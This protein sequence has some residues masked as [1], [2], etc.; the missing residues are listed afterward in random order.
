MLEKLFRAGTNR[1]VEK[2]T[3]VTSPTGE[4]V[5]TE[6]NGWDMLIDL[7]NLED[8]TVTPNSA[9][10]FNTVYAC[11]N[12]LSDDLAKLPWKAYKKTN[13]AITRGNSHPVDYLLNKRP[14]PHMNP[15]T[16]K[17]TLMVDVLTQ[18][19][20]YALIEYDEQGKPRVM[21][22]LTSHMTSYIVDEKTG[23]SGYRTKWRNNDILLQDYEVFHI[24]ALGN[25][26]EGVSP[27]ESVKLQ[28]E[29]SYLSDQFNNGMIRSG[30]VPK[31]IL[32]VQGAIGKEAK[33]NVRREWKRSNS[34][35]AIAIIDN[36]L[37]Y[38]SMGISQQD[39]QFV[40]AKRYNAQE[41]ASIFKIPLHKINDLDRATF[42][43]IE[44]QSLDYYKN[45]LLPWIVQWE[46]EANYKLFSNKELR[47]GWYTKFSLDSELRGD[48]K[49]RAEVQE[50]KMRSGTLTI[51]EV[52]D[53]DEM[54]PFEFELAKEPLI[55]LNLTSLKRLEEYQYKDN[56]SP[57]LNEPN[58]KKSKDDEQ[59]EQDEESPLE[60][61]DE[62]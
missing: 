25:G 55:S 40:E 1:T 2:R 18:G 7:L 60:G 59:Q 48:A 26:Y 32:K 34:A 29:G 11:V 17:K 10:S 53:Q 19:N 14:N 44:S 9:T 4:Q 50:I 38:Q 5:H 62:D 42:S 41:I 35:E 37:E 24:K 51:N 31:G 8:K 22:P 33:A 49:S 46:E 30:G 43:N 61:G 12:I 15:F 54:S 20:A 36:G 45:T 3:V 13:G 23:V 58:P 39:M 16:F 56:E 52:R 27:I 28:I 57:V 47:N 21:H 6:G